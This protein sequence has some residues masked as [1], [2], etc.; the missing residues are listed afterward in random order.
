M[1]KL[2]EKKII[3]EKEIKNVLGEELYKDSAR[4]KS[5]WG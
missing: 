5:C 2:T 4:V 3:L 1:F